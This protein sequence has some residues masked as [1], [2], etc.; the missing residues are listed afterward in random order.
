M[1]ALATIFALLPMAIGL[2]GTGGFISQPL[3]VVV[4]G[5]LVSSTAL[6]LVVL[7]VLYDLVE[8]GRE[9]RRMRRA[10]LPAEA[11]AV[12]AGVPATVGAAQ[13]TGQA[14]SSAGDG[15][16]GAPTAAEAPPS[17]DAPTSGETPV[18]EG[19]STAEEPPAEGGTADDAPPSPRS[20][21]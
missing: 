9:R 18:A 13:V 6:T 17:D 3:A 12:T 4:I 10:G 20:T 16:P 14:A 2:T 5:G 19:A 11:D 7:P 8:G 21:E 1:T 15:A